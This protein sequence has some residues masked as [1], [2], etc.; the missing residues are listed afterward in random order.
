MK[1]KFMFL[2]L[3]VAGAVLQSQAEQSP[4]QL[5]KKAEELAKDGNWKEALD[6]SRT[7]LES[8]D[9]SN[10]SKDLLSSLRYL[11]ELSLIHI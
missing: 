7:M 4:A 3:L 6:I 11:R 5:R 2:A 10:S 8:V 9:D 1:L